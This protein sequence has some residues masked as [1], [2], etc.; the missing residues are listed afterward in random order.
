M[1]ILIVDSNFVNFTAPC[2]NLI[3]HATLPVEPHGVYLMV[4]ISTLRD[5]VGICIGHVFVASDLLFLPVLHR[6]YQEFS[7]FHPTNS[8]FSEVSLPFFRIMSEPFCPF[9]V[10]PKVRARPVYII[11]IE[12]LSLE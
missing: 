6:L 10:D 9:P 1:E 5:D 3:L 8:P 11:N 12:N 7:Y 2:A 4:V